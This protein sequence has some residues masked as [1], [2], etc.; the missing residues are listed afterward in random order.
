MNLPIYQDIATAAIDHVE[1]IAFDSFCRRCS[2]GGAVGR[3]TCLKPVGKR[4]GVLVV[5]QSPSARVASSGRPWSSALERT[6]AGLVRGFAAGARVAFDYAVRCSGGGASGAECLP[7]LKH[8]LEVVAPKRVLAFGAVAA[9][10]LVGSAAPHNVRRSWSRLEDGAVVFCLPEPFHVQSNRVLM[11]WLREDIE[12]ALTVDLEQLPEPELCDYQLV[13]TETEAERVVDDLIDQVTQIDVETYGVLG[14]GDFKVVSLSL[15][16]EDDTE[17]SYVWPE[18]AMRE[19]APARR[20]LERL[21]RS[22]KLV[23]HNAKYESRA[24][25]AHFGIDLRDSL[26]GDTMVWAKLLRA[27]GAAGLGPL[28]W[29]V[30]MGGH[31]D[32]AQ[33][34]LANAVKVLRGLRRAADARVPTAVEVEER[35]NPKTGKTQRRKKVVESRAPS[36]QER[37]DQVVAAWAKPRTLNKQRTTYATEALSWQGPHEVTSPPKITADWLHAALSRGSVWSYVYGLIEPELCQR[38]NARDTLSTALLAARQRPVVDS[39]DT[40]GRVWRSHLHAAPWAVGKV[41]SWGVL[42]SLKKL[43]EAERFFTQRADELL[44]DIHAVKPGMNPAST[45]QLAELLYKDLKLPVLKKSRKTGKPSTDKPTLTALASSDDAPEKVREVVGKVLEWKSVTKLN[46]TYAKGLRAFIQSDG[47]IRCSLNIVGTET[48]RMSCSDPNMQTIPTRSEYA[49]RI[50][51]VFAAPPGHKLVQLDYKA[52]EVRIAA[53]LSGDP[54]LMEVFE[55]GGDPHRETA[56]ALSEVLW[57]NTFDTCGGLSGDDLTAEQARRRSVCKGVVFGTIYGQGPEAL[58]AMTGLTAAEAERAQT[59]VMG[60]YRVLKRWITKTAAAASRTGETWTWWDGGRARRRPVPDI[61]D[62]DP[63]RASHGQRQSYNTPVQ[64]TGSE[65]CVASLVAIVAW[66]V[67]S[68]FPAKLVMTVHDSL[69]FEVRDG[70]VDELIRNVARIMTGWESQG[71]DIAVDAE[72]GENWGDLAG[73][74]IP[75]AA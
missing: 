60:R 34:A 5:G 49:K 1:S 44:A 13:Q 25:D 52:L 4:G 71:V 23:A 3:T 29:S 43:G 39:S 17:N 24:C 57:G 47:R 50:K 35:I 51:S 19:G 63:G 6:V 22:G 14:E 48:G 8:S 73:Y 58:A 74:V 75:A 30:G 65:F 55:R 59:L 18:H 64:G 21:L 62:Q 12:W 54:V 67:D 16:P 41:E 28:A 37:R 72:V 46:G 70:H 66:L 33:E 56:E 32:E 53:M 26:V 2:L 68:G 7:Y 40:F 42:A 69:V 38:Y 9:R 36:E 20:P 31:K 61:G 45:D 15:T 11:G 27:D 10:S